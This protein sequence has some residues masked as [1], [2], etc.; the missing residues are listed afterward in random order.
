MAGTAQPA[1]NSRMIHRT[2][3]LRLKMEAFIK[4]LSYENVLLQGIL[5]CNR[6]NRGTRSQHLNN[7]SI[8]ADSLCC[9]GKFLLPHRRWCSSPTIRKSRNEVVSCE[10][11]RVGEE[12]QPG[13]RYS[14]AP[15][16]Y[17][18]N[19]SIVVASLSCGRKFFSS[20]GA[21]G[22]GVSRLAT[23]RTGA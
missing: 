6:K 7:F 2:Q 21:K 1:S 23:R 19:S 20:V 14:A 15:G 16:Q 3:V 12:H 4:E 17:F 8:A 5:A 9:G 22:I 13:R 18:D 10:S 11:A